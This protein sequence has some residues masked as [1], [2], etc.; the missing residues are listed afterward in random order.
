M[1]VE[2]EGVRL[3]REW[4]R[5][6]HR[7]LLVLLEGRRSPRLLLLRAHRAPLMAPASEALP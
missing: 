6:G 3:L 2:D 5:L 1:D 4:V 7:V